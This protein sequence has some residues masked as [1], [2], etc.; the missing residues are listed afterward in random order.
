M[1][2]EV[3]VVGGSLTGLSCALALAR[4]GVSS[5]VV[6]RVEARNR[7][8][9]GLGVDRG[10][11]QHVTGL[12]PFRRTA[13]PPLPVVSSY[14]ESTSWLA[15]HNWLRENALAQP[16]V[17]VEEGVTLESIEDD[18]H[19][20][21]AKTADGRRLTARMLIGA[22][23]YRSFVR[24]YVNPDK[25]YASYA[26]YMLWRGLVDERQMDRNTA[27]ATERDGFG[28]IDGRG[29]RLI[30]YPVPGVDGSVAPG[31][32]QISFAWYDTHRD[33]LLRATGCLSSTG[34]V[35]G[36]LA[37]PSV[38][39]S[40]RAELLAIARDTWPEP[41]RA[42]VDYAI[43]GP[44]LFGTPICE[45]SPPRLVRGN[46]AIMGDAAHVASPMTGRGFRTGIE[47]ADTLARTVRKLRQTSGTFSSR[48]VLH[49]FQAERLPVARALATASKQAS[50][51]YLLIATRGASSSLIRA[52]N[53]GSRR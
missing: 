1:D 48:D 25:P 53:S 20:V 24:T 36:T 17:A 23:G 21:T 9:G 31:E 34:E 7:G 10:L 28:M 37:G 6:E 47:D 38:D 11:L 45:Y 8:G 16:L 44:L 4:Y 3:L 5:R 49:R 33:D 18:S 12:D 13:S 2:G 29:Y 39:V 50:K 35:L 46:L 27:W 51:D 14:R 41:W 32:R 26:G 15:L 42:A 30:A 22:D 40:L 43:Q 19:G 52:A